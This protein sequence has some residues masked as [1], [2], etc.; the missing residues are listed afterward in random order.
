MDSAT[1]SVVGTLVGAMIGGLGTYLTTSRTTARTLRVQ[2]EMNLHDLDAAHEQN[3]QNMQ[4]PVYVQAIAALN[5]RRDKREHDLNPQ[6]DWD[7]DKD[8]Y[9]SVRTTLADYDPPNWYESQSQLVLY[10]PQK[11]LDL[12]KVAN[13]AHEEVLRQAR[14]LAVF[15]AHVAVTDPGDQDA[16]TNLARQYE[17]LF[18]KIKAALKNAATADDTLIQLMRKSVHVPPSQY[19]RASPARMSKF[20]EIMRLTEPNSA[21]GNAP[22][23][24]GSTD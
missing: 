22:V 1:L 14:G 20:K 23:G 8:A 11:V 21:T 7:K 5:Y 13:D 10:A 3:L 2:T 6:I 24:P 17:D 18:A 4:A 12:N 19:L 15:R 16:R 9:R